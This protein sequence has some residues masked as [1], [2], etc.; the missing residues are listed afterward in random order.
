MRTTLSTNN[1][2]L[3]TQVFVANNF[4][5]QS[6]LFTR[7]K[8]L[9]EQGKIRLHTTHITMGE[10]DRNIRE[11]VQQAQRASSRVRKEGKILFNCKEQSFENVL[12]FNG[13]AVTLELIKQLIEFISEYK[14][15][16]IPIEGVS[17]TKIFNKYFT[18]QPPF[19]EGNKKF[20]FPDAFVLAALENWC[21]HNREK[22]YV[23]SQDEDLVNACGRSSVLIS[24]HKIEELLEKASADARTREIADALFERMREMFDIEVRKA[25]E[26]S[27]YWLEDVEGEV[28]EVFVDGIN[29][30]EK[31]LVSVDEEKF[32]FEA[33]YEVEL[34]ANV[35]YEDPAHVYYDNDERRYLGLDLVREK[36]T[37]FDRC[38]ASIDIYIENEDLEDEESDLLHVPYEVDVYMERPVSLNVQA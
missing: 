10:V 26:D 30:L 22:M 2:F 27:G 4:S 24:L 12:R 34:S 29:L 3:D 37:N 28:Y 36:L 7:L 19:S 5:Y 21:E 25:Y 15:N 32:S 20:E 16:T 17:P 1:V 8:D 6:R 35:A 13:E 18:N 23:I 31:H 14:V 9:I 38:S 33:S 11:A